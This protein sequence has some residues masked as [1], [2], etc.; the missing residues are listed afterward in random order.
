MDFH[1][2]NMPGEFDVNEFEK[3]SMEKIG[4]INEIIPRYRPTY[5][6][7]A[8]SWGYSSGY[9]SYTWAEVLDADAALEAGLDLRDEAQ[10]RPPV[11]GLR[12]ALALQQPVG[13][14][15]SE[16]RAAAVSWSMMQ[17]RSGTTART[18]PT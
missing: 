8:F 9:Y 7:H 18:L 15:R 5:F 13:C 10:Q 1:T 6:A 17:I 14:Q 11:V 3:K 4:L 12:E 2:V 16:V